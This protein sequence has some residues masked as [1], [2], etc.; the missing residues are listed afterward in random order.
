MI[1]VQ[2]CLPMMQEV[3]HGFCSPLYIK[4]KI[5][6]SRMTLK[7]QVYLLLGQLKKL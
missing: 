6:F 3:M 5:L 4:K 7:I 2:E 1:E